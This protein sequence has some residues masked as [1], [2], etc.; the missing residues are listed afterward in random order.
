MSL[1]L[2]AALKFKKNR[3]ELPFECRQTALAVIRQECITLTDIFGEMIKRGSQLRSEREYF[4][5]L[6]ELVC[7]EY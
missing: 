2:A 5:E 1:K 6:F 4:R 7:M 3:N